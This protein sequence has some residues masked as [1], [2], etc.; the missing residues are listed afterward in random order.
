MFTTLIHYQCGEM[1]MIYI[2]GFLTAIIL[3]SLSL[4]HVYWAFGGKS[5]LVTAIPTADGQPL[6]TPTPTDT[7]LVAFALL[8]A[9]GVV[10]GNFGYRIPLLPAWSYRIGIWGIAAVFLLRAIGEFRYIGFFKQVRDTPFAR[11]DTLLYSPLCLFLA[12]C[13]LVV[14][15]STSGELS[16]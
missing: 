13:C 3:F 7:F 14:A 10:F 15:I 6:F 5:G 1:K 9:A 16:N 2:I 12:V 4:L 8:S 11:Q